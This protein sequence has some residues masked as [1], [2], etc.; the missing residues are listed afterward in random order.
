MNKNRFLTLLDP[1]ECE[2][3]EFRRNHEGHF[4]AKPF[5]EHVLKRKPYEVKCMVFG[6]C[7]TCLSFSQNDGGLKKFDETFERTKLTFRQ[8]QNQEDFF[9]R[10][11]QRLFGKNKQIYESARNFF[12]DNQWAQAKKKI[13]TT[14][15]NQI[16]EDVWVA[17]ARY[18][19]GVISFLEKD[20]EG[21][22]NIFNDLSRLNQ[23]S[24]RGVRDQ[25]LLALGRIAFEQKDYKAAQTYFDALGDHTLKD[26]QSVLESSWVALKNNQH[27]MAQ[28][29]LLSLFTIYPSS[30]QILETATLFSEIFQRS[31]NEAAGEKSIENISERIEIEVKSSERYLASIENEEEKVFEAF[32]LTQK[33][34]TKLPFLYKLMLKKN[35]L[36]SKW[37]NDLSEVLDE[38]ETLSL[39]NEE[40]EGLKKYFASTKTASGGGVF[41]KWLLDLEKSM[42][43]LPMSA[44]ARENTSKDLLELESLNEDLKHEVFQIQAHMDLTWPLHVGKQ[45]LELQALENKAE[46]LLREIKKNQ[47]LIETKKS[48]SV[49]EHLQFAQTQ[50]AADEQWTH[51]QRK[52]EHADLYAKLDE[53]KKAVDAWSS[54]HASKIKNQINSLMQQNSFLQREVNFFKNSKIKL[55]RPEIR[56]LLKEALEDLKNIQSRFNWSLAE[57][58][59][60]ILNQNKDISDLQIQKINAEI[61]AY[62]GLFLPEEE[63]ASINSKVFTKSDSNFDQVSKEFY[64]KMNRY[65]VEMRSGAKADFDQKMAKYQKFLSD[66][67]TQTQIKNA[68]LREKALLAYR[69]FQTSVIEGEH[70]P[71]VLYRLAELH[72]E[73]I[74]NL[75]QS[76]SQTGEKI[77]NDYAVVIE[78][79]EEIQNK[80][81][82][83]KYRDRALYM[84]GFVYLANNENQK[85]QNVFEEV[86]RQYPDSEVAKD[87]QFRLAE[88]YFSQKNFKE[89]VKRYQTV[90]QDESHPHFA[91]ALYKLAWSKYSLAEYEKAADYFFEILD[92][93]ASAPDRLKAELGQFADEAMQYVAFSLYRQGGANEA[94]AA[95]NLRGWKP[96]SFDVLSKM[97]EI[98]QDRRDDFAAKNI[99]ELM[100]K[101]YPSHERAPE[102]Y[103]DEIKVIEKIYARDQV[104]QE[105]EKVIAF[106]GPSQAWAKA[107]AD[108]KDALKKAENLVKRLQFSVATEY[109][110]LND[111]NKKEVY[112][113]KAMD[114]YEA[115]A[116]Q[117]LES[118]ESYDARYRLGELH[119][120]KGDYPKAIANYDQII[121]A[122][123]FK[124]HFADALYNRVACREKWIAE[125]NLDSKSR[126]ELIIAIDAFVEGAPKDPRAPQAYFRSAQ[127]EATLKN[128]ESAEKRFL[129]MPV[130]FPNHTWSEQAMFASV[131]MY[132]DD[133]NWKKASTL[134]SQWIARFPNMSEEQKKQLDQFKEGSEFKSA[135]ES[136]SS[137]LTFQKEFPNSTLASKA[138]FNAFVLAQKE[139]NAD[140]ALDAL[141]ILEEK[142]P[143][144]PEAKDAPF[145]KAIVYD[146]TFQKDEAL[147]QYEKL[148]KDA[149]LVGDKKDKVT[150]NYLSL[151]AAQSFEKNEVQKN[152]FKSFILSLPEPHKSAATL[153]YG[154][155]LGDVGLYQALFEA[156]QTR[157]QARARAASRLSAYYWRQNQ[158][159]KA[160]AFLRTAQ[161]LGQGLGER[162]RIL[163]L[164]DLSKT[165][166]DYIRFQA[167]E[168]EA[169]KIVASSP[170]LLQSTF[171][172]KS[173]ILGKLEKSVVDLLENSTPDLQRE[174]LSTLSVQYKDFA[175]SIENIVLPKE[176]P[177]LEAQ[178]IKE[179]F[180]GL[181]EPLMK[182]SLQ[183]QEKALSIQSLFRLPS[184]AKSKKQFDWALPYFPIL[185]KPQSFVPTP[186]SS[187][188]TKKQFE[189]G[190]AFLKEPWTVGNLNQA[191]GHF[192]RVLFDVPNNVPALLNRLLAEIFLKKF[193]DAHR[194]FEV[195]KSAAPNQT[196]K[197]HHALMAYFKGSFSESQ[198]L[199]A[200]LLQDEFD[201]SLSH[202]NFLSLIG[203]HQKQKALEFAQGFFKRAPKTVLAHQMLAQAYL[204]KGEIA[205][206]KTILN[207]GL[208]FD[209]ENKD[210][211]A[212]LALTFEEEPMV[213]S[214]LFEEASKKRSLEALNNWAVLAH[215][216]GDV[217][218]AKKDFKTLSDL[219]GGLHPTV[220]KNMAYFGLNHDQ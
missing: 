124:H 38:S 136:I 90:I 85:A 20:V 77:K 126:Q 61:D 165:K 25:A 119:F 174:A 58:R 1:G 116:T 79:L 43:G 160:F 81:K 108:N 194:T 207:R 219:G 17:K 47:A 176:I 143:T 168:N 80:H 16:K 115:I 147:K 129:E 29:D 201:A 89:S 125:Q 206:T 205:F 18:I 101:Q 127:V 100:L 110:S 3:K 220:V 84:L 154:E 202:L 151:M 132:A 162:D 95:F 133:Q 163:F 128:F 44:S 217:E 98:A 209:P 137:Y 177:T 86:S 157:A 213:Q 67:E 50:N 11:P 104:A 134:S 31:Q 118:K 203:D 6:V 146:E 7:L 88:V 185:P 49:L 9:V 210:L 166:M 144:S 142:Y 51:T 188:Q 27:Q 55:Y 35:P 138:T 62:V 214:Q 107:N 216:A 197:L 74:K 34:K 65:L 19:Q 99:F 152:K 48:V 75:E 105:K 198:A 218:A 32:G 53:R 111:Q 139:G 114:F 70:R 184:D 102:I 149:K 57:S 12:L 42:S 26:P 190:E 179:G 117:H 83:F 175:Q 208:G 91:K 178:K 52:P 158:T 164:S 24:Q 40:L 10:K 121:K 69:K 145:L 186:K 56:K 45:T 2:P 92:L 193:D 212:L 64:E 167:R 87:A 63:P 22:K 13:A 195:L 33:S 159:N 170:K 155:R 106:F 153:D 199:C 30:P 141:S 130:R 37:V 54:E 36:F 191:I 60:R 169:E 68:E 215:E 204:A 113:S 46:Q 72:F 189:M 200:E 112:L 123:T 150:I 109:E 78:P 192:N 103:E 173:L 181:M 180:K 28:N 135:G 172:K 161:V 211:K 96:Y 171:Q 71:Q 131:Q 140:A 4:P 41:K 93:N 82:N 39:K 14:D 59:Y 66:L 5:M 23:A 15:L 97:S 182:K 94:Q 73:R 156:S 148:I 120:E 183:A 76:V 8:N 21:A 122:Q 196:P 187:A